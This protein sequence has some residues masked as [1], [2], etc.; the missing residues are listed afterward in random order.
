M[1]YTKIFNRSYL[2]NLGL[3]LAFSSVSFSAYAVPYYYVDWTSWNPSGGTAVGTITPSSGPA[4]TV[5]FDALT[6]TGAHGSFLG[7]TGNYLWNPTGAYTSAQVDNAS[8]YEGIQLVGTQNMTYRVTL[9]EA[10]KDPIMAVTT[11]GSGGDSAT[12]VFD[13]PFTILSQG[14]TCCWGGGNNRLSQLPGNVLQGFEGAGTI[15]FIGTYTT[16]SW[17]VPDPEYWHGFTFG[18]RTTE[19]LEPTSPVPEPETYAMLLAGLGLLGVTA[20]RRARS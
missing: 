11:L 12:Y 8:T 14:V 7:V 6:S 4:V 20:R 19:H 3:A 1:P 10:I 13:S 15:Q 9:S 16:F 5:A 18:I 17:T 2:T